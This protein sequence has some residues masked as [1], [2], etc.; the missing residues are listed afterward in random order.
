MSSKYKKMSELNQQL[1]DRDCN[2]LNK[3]PF[4]SI[5]YNLSK[6]VLSQEGQYSLYAHIIPKE[7]SKYEWDKYY[8]GISNHIERRWRSKGVEYKNIPFYNAI[9]KYGWENIKHCIL[10]TNLTKEQAEDFEKRIIRLLNTDNRLYGYNRSLGGTGGNNK[11]VKPVKQYT[12]EG[13]YLKTWASESEAAR[14]YGVDRTNI[15]GVVKKK[16][17]STAGYMWCYADE[18]ITEPYKRKSPTYTKPRYSLSKKIE[19]IETHTIYNSI[20]EA[21]EICK[22]S[23]DCIIKNLKGRTKDFRG[24]IFKGQR[25]HWRYC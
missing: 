22:T 14:F 3:E 6:E 12:L 21:A 25:I 4:K 10:F 18:E 9:T 13:Q 1:I 11:S 17:K 2:E 20:K 19:C 8:I 7:L 5:I 15:S 16:T 23:P 24:G